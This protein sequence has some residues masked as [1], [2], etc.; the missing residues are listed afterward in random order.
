MLLDKTGYGQKLIPEKFSRPENNLL[1]QEAYLH[2][3]NM[4]CFAS[5]YVAKQ[6]LRNEIWIANQ[7]DKECKQLLLQMIEWQ[8][9][10]V[11]GE[12]YDT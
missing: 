12:T 3:N 7:R 11:N 6:I 9:K 4:F 8:A 5:L 2:V 10:A 1:T